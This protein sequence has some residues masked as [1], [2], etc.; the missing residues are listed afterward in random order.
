MK[1]FN[2]EKNRTSIR[3]KGYDYSSNGLY[4]VTSC[5]V[6]NNHFFGEVVEGKMRLNSIG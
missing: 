4:F 6:K 1:L 3:F 2:S 5:C